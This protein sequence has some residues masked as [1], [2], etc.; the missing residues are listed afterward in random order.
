MDFISQVRTL[1]V[2]FV[3]GNV[4]WS[5]GLLAWLC[6]GL[7]QVNEPTEGDVF[8]RVG[9]PLHLI[10][11][12]LDVWFGKVIISCGDGCFTDVCYS[13]EEMQVAVNELLKKVQKVKK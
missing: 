5:V 6:G 13:K 12:G 11:M 3:G 10:L 4:D 2:L 9:T 1:S 7:R 8:P